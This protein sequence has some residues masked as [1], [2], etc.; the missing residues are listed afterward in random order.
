MGNNKDNPY[1]CM[2]FTLNLIVFNLND[3][4]IYTKKRQEK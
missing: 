4:S 1:F 3:V 2:C